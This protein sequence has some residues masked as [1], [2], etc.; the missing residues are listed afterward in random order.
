[1]IAYIDLLRLSGKKGV[2]QLSIFEVAIIITLG[3]A[4]GDPMFNNE[5]AILPSL[6][7][8][9]ITLAFHRALTYFAS[10]NEK[11]ENVLEGEAVYIIEDGMMSRNYFSISGRYCKIGKL[12][13]VWLD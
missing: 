13:R 7:V 2:R 12:Q 10:K 4:A 5:F 9:M 3:S 1:M 11:F 6:L 8:F